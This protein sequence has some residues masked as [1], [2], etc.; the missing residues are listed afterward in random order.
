MLILMN[1]GTRP[2]L[3]S[4]VLMVTSLV[5]GLV[6]YAALQAEEAAQQLVLGSLPSRPITYT[7][8]IPQAPSGCAGSLDISIDTGNNQATVTMKGWILVGAFGRSEPATFDASLVF[9]ALGQLSASFM[10]CSSS[11][12]SI[13]FGTLGVNPITAQVFKG[14]DNSP[15]LFEQVLAGPIELKPRNGRYEII[16]PHLSHVSSTLP[17]IDLPFSLEVATNES[18][19]QANGQAIDLTPLIQKLAA[20]SQKVRGALPPL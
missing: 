10:R 17:N 20:F 1:Q 16:A 18:C 8:K 12:G 4:L 19:T 5:V 9:N 6:S 11:N 15:P 13:R 2:L 3:L 14:A 7:I